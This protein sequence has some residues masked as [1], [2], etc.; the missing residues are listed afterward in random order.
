MNKKKS[1]LLAPAGSFMSAYYAFEA[2]ADAVYLGLENFS[3]RKSAQNFNRS[4]L[5]KIKRIA[6]EKNKKIYVT[7]NTVIKESE[8]DELLSLLLECEKLAIDG[9]IIQDFGV[10]DLVRTY[11]PGIPVH[12]STQMA[13]HNEH[14]IEKAIELGIERVVL[15]REL[16]FEDVRR[17]KRRF[18]EMELEVFIHGALCYSYSGLCLASGLMA[19]RSGNRGEC[20][21]VCRLP[22]THLGR[23]G[24]VLSCRDLF[25][26]EN[27][28]RL[29]DA[30]IDSLKMEGR[31]KPPEY[32]YNTVRLYRYIIDHPGCRDNSEFEELLESSELV[33]SREK[34]NGYLFGDKNERIIT[35][36]YSRSI[37]HIVGR[38]D[39]RSEDSFSFLSGSD[40]SIDDVL[41]FFLDPR[42]TVPYKLPV[43][44]MWVD[45][46]K[47]VKAIKGTNVTVGS[48]KVPEPGQ[49]IF[50][51][52]AKRLE[53]P[54]IRHKDFRYLKKKIVLN[55]LCCSNDT[56][57][58][59]IVA[60][61]GDRTFV[62]TH[63][64]VFE[65]M[66]SPV[67]TAGHIRKIFEDKYDP[68]FEFVIENIDLESI[69]SKSNAAIPHRLL[70]NIRTGF[71]DFIKNLYRKQDAD[72]ISAIKENIRVLRP[73]SINTDISDIVDFIRI[74]KNLN[75]KHEILPFHMGGKIDPKS[76][77]FTGTSC[78]IPMKPVVNDI[79]S[80]YYSELNEFVIKNADLRIFLG[81]NNLHHIKIVEKLIKHPNVFSFVDFFFYIANKLTIG[82]ILKEL[83]KVM[84]G[85]F[86]IEGNVSDY[87]YL[88]QVSGF[89]LFRIDRSFRPPYFF[90]AGSFAKESLVQDRERKNNLSDLKWEDFD[91][92]LI[93]EC[94]STYIFCKG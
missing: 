81:V 23:E 78:F 32:V 9:V 60:T 30:G 40:I 94:G 28:H 17:L 12:A 87:E 58:F 10:L 39:I 52:Y 86:W 38:V 83:P 76:I 54:G 84:F 26:G 61:S 37:G 68:E 72:K 93:E 89:P 2:G 57:F 21:Q 66:R 13:I 6:F 27:V 63:P 90:H 36:V 33:F 55:I 64:C 31:L 19:G 73:Q 25:S 70:R 69:G 4:E 85:Y 65:Y 46:I 43:R 45:G 91:F 8:V 92:R 3:A 74:R 82:F 29:I 14:G 71:I 88:K 34:T 18:P 20:A 49:E 35:S 67:D 5:S 59:K 41:Q 15:P 53:L 79:E 50:K 42:E 47:V 51:V 1:E 80:K 16:R 11:F 77:A 22:F 24:R 75:P 56:V 44:N 7:L 62:Y 48:V